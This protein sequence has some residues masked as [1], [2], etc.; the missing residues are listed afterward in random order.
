MEQWLYDAEVFSSDKAFFDACVL[1][2]W[3]YSKLA[4]VFGCKGWEIKTYTEQEC[5]ILGALENLNSPSIIQVKVP[6]KSIPD[7]AKWKEK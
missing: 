6:Q 3:N 7:N 1:H 5:A 2:R 4:D